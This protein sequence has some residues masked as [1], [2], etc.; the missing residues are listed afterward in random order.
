MNQSEREVQTAKGVKR[1]LSSKRRENPGF[2]N[3]R[4]FTGLAAGGEYKS[5]PSHELPGAHESPT[6]SRR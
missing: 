1:W 5:R 6:R 4:R 2:S 3:F